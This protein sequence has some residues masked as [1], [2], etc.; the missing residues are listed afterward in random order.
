M[1]LALPADTPELQREAHRLRYRVYCLERGFEDPAQ[2]PGGLERDA[3]DGHAVQALLLHRMT[4]QALG[5]VRL[6]LHRS[7]A[8]HGTLPIHSICRDPRLG[9]PHILPFE[10]TAELSRLAISKVIRRCEG[11]DLYG[12]AARPDARVADGRCAVPQLTLG[13]MTVALQMGETYGVEQVCAVMEPALL[14]LVARFGL[15]FRPLGPL[16]EYHGLRQPCYARVDELLAGVAATRPDVWTAMTERSRL[17]RSRVRPLPA[18]S[19]AALW[20]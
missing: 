4:G 16:V 15:C 20:P 2:N 7:G 9:D 18:P 8:R 19:L 17:R 12:D 13:L 11:V 5:T 3:Y 14:R 1:F 6:V 10:T